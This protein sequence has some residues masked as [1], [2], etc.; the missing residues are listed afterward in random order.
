VRVLFTYGTVLTC[1]RG[2][3]IDYAQLKFSRVALIGDSF[4]WWPGTENR[5]LELMDIPEKPI[6]SAADLCGL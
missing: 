6:G 1:Q 4:T 5:K 2:E 3:A